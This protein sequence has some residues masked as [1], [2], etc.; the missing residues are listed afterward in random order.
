VDHR[1]VRER[2]I[3]EC[4]HASAA[5]YLFLVTVSDAQGLSYYSDATLMRRLRMDGPTLE[6]S[7]R[8]LIHLGL[9]AFK[10]PIYQ[11]LPLEAQAPEPAPTPGRYVGQTPKRSADDPRLLG[12]IFRSFM[13]RDS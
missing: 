1:L 8:L 7:R 6:D 12:D 13:E 9:V 2:R 5:L 10:K 11:V 3:D 4:T